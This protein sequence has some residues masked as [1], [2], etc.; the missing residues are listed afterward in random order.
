MAVLVGS[1]VETGSVSTLSDLG[2]EP[3]N[4]RR[5]LTSKSLLPARRAN[6]LLVLETNSEA[7]TLRL[8]SHRD[9]AKRGS[10]L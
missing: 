8:E 7:A 2:S 1:E 6:E 10:F 4:C 5:A 3:Y 9:Q